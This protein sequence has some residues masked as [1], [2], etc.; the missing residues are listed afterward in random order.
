ML[1]FVQKVIFCHFWCNSNSAQYNRNPYKAIWFQQMMLDSSRPMMGF[2]STWTVKF[3][4]WMKLG[5]VLYIVSWPETSEFIK[6]RSSEV[7]LIQIL[8]FITSGDVGIENRS[9]IGLFDRISRNHLYHL[10]Q[11][12][13]LYEIGR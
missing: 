8:V 12:A 4:Y 1:F 6:I 2:T 9:K 11:R 7:K 10:N 13:K 3:D 5:F